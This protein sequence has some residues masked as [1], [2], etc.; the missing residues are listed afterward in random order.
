[1]KDMEPNL[2]LETNL[3][4]YTHVFAAILIKLVLPSLFGIRLAESKL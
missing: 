1:L 4:Y 2:L 3:L